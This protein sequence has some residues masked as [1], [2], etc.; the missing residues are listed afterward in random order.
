MAKKILF[1]LAGLALLLT[2]VFVFFLKPSLSFGQCLSD[3]GLVMYGTDTCS[4]CKQQKQILGEDFEN[5]QYVNCFFSLDSCRKNKIKAYPTWK[6]NDK[7]YV[8]IQ[9]QSELAEISGCKLKNS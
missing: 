4:S 9:T 6:K 1:I 2:L 7:L 5:I 3:N 8:G